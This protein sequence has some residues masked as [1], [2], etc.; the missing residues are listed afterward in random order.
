MKKVL[1]WTG[2]VLGTLILI[3]LILAAWIQFSATPKHEVKPV[4]IVLP[5]DSLSL[6]RGQK[7]VTTIC[8]YCHLGED[9]KLSGKMISPASEPGFGELWSANITQHPTKG[10]GSYT[11]G[12]LAYLLRTGVNRDGRMSG[13]MMRFP[14]MSDADVAALIAYLRSDAGINQP[15]EAVHPFPEYPN[16]FLGKFLTKIGVF[17]PLPYD[18]TPITAPDPSDQ[19]AY[20]RYLATGVY[21]CYSCHSASF[22]TNNELDPEKSANYFGGGNLITDDEFN[23]V[24]SRNITPSK[25]HGIGNWTAEQLSAAIRTGVRPDGSM[26][27][28]QMPRFANLDEQEVA[29]I[30]AYL[31]TVPAID[32][33][34]LATDSK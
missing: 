34:P 25:T 29:A 17:D 21:E 18:G 14:K 19:I 30:W 3:I 24:P 23:K 33:D 16:K 4:D 1:K 10:I 31:Q 13:I 9:G 20:G 27:K 22:E 26:L 5:T 32:T 12:E 28:V 8:A 11:D 7:I 2:I 6:A 15:S